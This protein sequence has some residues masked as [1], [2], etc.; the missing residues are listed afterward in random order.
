MD[1]GDA[2]ADADPRVLDQAWR[3]WASLLVLGALALG[4]GAGLLLLPL[5]QGSAGGVDAFTAICRS[6]GIAAG[7]PAVTAPPSD[8]RAQPV[9]Q[10]A[11]S[12]GLIERLARPQA[13]A[14]R[15]L[16]DTCAACH[17]ERGISA[18]PAV[19]N[20][21][22]QSGLALFKQLS[23]YRSGVRVNDVM[24]PLAQALDD[25]QVVTAAGWFASLAKGTLDPTTAQVLDPVIIRLVERGDQARGIPACASCHGL[26]AGGPIETPSISGQNRAYLANQLRL[27]ARGERRNDLYQRMRLIAAALTDVEIERL[28]EFYA[29]TL[30]R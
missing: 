2:M 18:D 28:A 23:D 16:A 13:E 6:L 1:R 5:V 30:T 14:G 10:V 11:W 20:L 9:S 29:T 12:S 19:P 22:G 25:E 8:A 27:Y 21:A 24:T 26:R 17:G 15:A 7:T 3:R 4:A